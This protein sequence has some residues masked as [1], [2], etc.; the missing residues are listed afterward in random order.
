MNAGTAL[1]QFLEEATLAADVD[2]YDASIDAVSLMT[3][4]AAKGLEFTEVMLCGVE[5]GSLP[6]ENG[7]LDE[8]RRLFYV[9]LTRAKEQVFLLHCRS[10]FL[11]GG[12]HDREPSRFLQEFD[13]SL[14]D[15]TVMP[16]RPRRSKPEPEQLS[17]LG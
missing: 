1:R 16:D 13:D 9:G 11:F 8:E 17:L 12:R 10:R 4:H 5:E 6:R 14:K 15:A 3:I 7:D 2:D